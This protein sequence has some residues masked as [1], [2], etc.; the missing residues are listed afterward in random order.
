MTVTDFREVEGRPFNTRVGTSLDMGG[1][2]DLFLEALS[3]IGH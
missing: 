3:R 1:F 2:W